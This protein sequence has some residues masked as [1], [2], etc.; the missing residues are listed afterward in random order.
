MASYKCKKCSA[1]NTVLKEWI[2]LG[3]NRVVSCSSCGYKMNLNLQPAPSQKKPGTQV[4]ENFQRHQHTTET[5]NGTNVVGVNSKKKHTY[6]LQVLKSDNYSKNLEIKELI[7]SFHIYIGRNPLSTI[8]NFNNDSDVIWIVNDPYVSRKH[9]VV[10]VKINNNKV[11]FILEDLNSANG[12]I[13]NKHK[14]QPK[15]QIFL[16]IGDEVVIGSTTFALKQV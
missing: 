4:V 13:V 9:C 6:M 10:M 16:N 3:I 1:K 15:D 12:T 7:N 5:P 8:E 11:Q 14:L 2:T